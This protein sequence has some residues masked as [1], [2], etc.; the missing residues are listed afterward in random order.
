VASQGLNGLFVAGFLVAGQM[1]LNAQADGDL[2]ASV[3]GL[4][5]FVTGAGLLIGNLLCGWLRAQAGGELAQ[6]FA[7]GAGITALL[8]LVFL[9]GFRDRPARA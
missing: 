1:F 7:V 9:V 8:V 5:S 6:T 2:R 3:Q 4:F